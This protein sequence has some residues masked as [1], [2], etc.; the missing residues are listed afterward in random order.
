MQRISISC[1]W[2]CP[3]LNFPGHFS[4]GIVREFFRNK[5]IW[6]ILDIFKIDMESAITN[7]K[8]KIINSKI[9]PEICPVS[10]H[11]PEKLLATFPCFTSCKNYFLLVLTSWLSIYLS[12]N[13]E[14]VIISSIQYNFYLSKYIYIQIIFEKF[15]HI[16]KL[17]IILFLTKLFL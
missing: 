15:R 7:Y 2:V 9:R 11:F 17:D 14:I 4:P 1:P 16:W 12:L 13:W 6:W 8:E 3:F 5:K 10:H